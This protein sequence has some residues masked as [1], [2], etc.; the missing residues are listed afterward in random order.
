V[1]DIAA[2]IDESQPPPAV[3]P[4]KDAD[5]AARSRRV[6]RCVVALMLYQGFT[7][8]IMGTGAPW[9]A[10]SFGLNQSGIARTFA[11]V[12]LS[13]F[14]ALALSRMVDRVGRRRVVLWSMLGTPLSALGAALSPNVEWLIVSSIFMFAFLGAAIASGIVML[15]EELA[16]D[17]RAKGQS[18]AALAGSLGAGL[19]ILV[20]PLLARSIYNWRL[21]FGISALGIALWPT[22][23]RLVPESRR[24][25]R[26][27]AAGAPARTS[28][29]AVFS[30]AYRRR[31]VV[32]LICSLFGATAA[33]GTDS[34]LYFHAV[35]VV[36]LSPAITSTLI[37][38]GGGI[39]LAGFALGA[40]SSEYFGRVRTVSVMWPLA[41]I[42]A[43]WYYWGPPAHF[44]WPALR[45]GAGFAWRIAMVNG[46]TVAAN[47]AVT[48]LFPTALRGT[49]VG[50]AAITNSLGA[51]AAHSS[52]ALL[53][54]PLG[55]LSVVVSYLALFGLPGA[56]LYGFFIHETRGM[57]LEA[58]SRE[59]LPG[60]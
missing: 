7:I 57:T 48:E 16:V 9:I 3:S 38:A 10:R 53:A 36:H 1:P 4:L 52:V 30:P 15:A 14:G 8:A 2:P 59:T 32:I 35:T 43:L 22:M 47:S 21:L 34:W 29:Y 39:G 31:S 18:Y 6:I 23:L 19:C 54:G 13:A 45:L 50:W 11:W 49:I 33:T 44:A 24:W 26:A 41:A 20:M 51:L 37:L 17:D 12:S 42:G 27:A 56:L 60:S 5:A 25:E 55:G 28:F 58:A 46:L 40:W